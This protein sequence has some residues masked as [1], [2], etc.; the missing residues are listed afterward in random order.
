MRRKIKIFCLQEKLPKYVEKEI[1]LSSVSNLVSFKICRKNGFSVRVVYFF[2]PTLGSSRPQWGTIE[3]I[4]ISTHM[5]VSL[6]GHPRLFLGD[7]KIAVRNYVHRMQPQ[8]TVSNPLSGSIICSSIRR[9]GRPRDFCGFLHLYQFPV[10]G[11]SVAMN[12]FSCI[13]NDSKVPNSAIKLIST[14]SIN[15][16]SPEK[17]VTVTILM[18]EP[19]TIPHI[20]LQ[21]RVSLTVIMQ[22]LDQPRTQLYCLGLFFAR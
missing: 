14:Q 17:S 22:V 8:A 3:L 13:C 18:A 6:S 21:Y 12:L 5:S 10:W 4:C 7:Y 9:P 2:I 19:V 11:S 15:P 16:P 20:F 1:D